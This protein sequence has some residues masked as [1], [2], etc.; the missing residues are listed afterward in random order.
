MAHRSRW[1]LRAG[2]L[3]PVIAVAIMGIAGVAAIEDIADRRNT[4]S[5]IEQ[6]AVTIQDRILAEI[7]Q[8]QRAEEIFT[9]LVADRLGI[10]VMVEESDAARLR[11]TLTPLAEELNLGYLGVYTRDNRELLRLGAGDGRDDRTALTSAL[12]GQASSTLAGSPQGLDIS[13]AGPIRSAGGVIGAVLVSTTVPS[14]GLQGLRGREAAEL[15]VYQ[16]G[17]LVASTTQDTRIT[18]LLQ[19]NRGSRDALDQLNDGLDD[20]NF[21]AAGFPLARNGMLVTIVAVDDLITAAWNR[22]VVGVIGTAALMVA[23]LLVYFMVAE[24]MTRTLHSVIGATKELVIG[25]Y[26]WRVK[27]STIRELD[28]LAG[29][30]NNLGQQLE[31]HVNELSHRAF[32]DPLT[33]LPNRAMLLDRLET[34]LARTRRSGRQIALIFCDLDNF[35]VVNDTLGHEAGDELLIS[36]ANRLQSTIRPGDTSARL[37]GDEFVVLL[38]DLDRP[39]DAHSVASRV[40]EQ[41]RAPFLLGGQEVFISVSIGAKVSV[42][43]TDQPDDL[44]RDAD[45]A[46]YRAKANGKGRYEIFD[47]VTDRVDPDRLQ[48]ETDLR[49]AIERDELRV[50]YQPIWHLATRRMVGVEALVRWQHPERGLLAPG[51]FVPLAEQIGLIL[52]I[53]RFVLTQACR[54]A[55][56]WHLRYPGPAP[57]R[58]SVNLSTRVFERPELID[59]IGATLR[60][61]GLDPSL[62]N[63]EITETVMMRQVERTHTELHKLKEL[64]VKLSVDD[65][66][67]G[68]SSLAYLRRFPINTVKVDRAFVEHLGQDPEDTAIVGAIVTLARTLQLEVVAEGIETADQLAHL[69]NLGCDYGQGFY[70]ARPVPANVIEALLAEGV[71]TTSGHIPGN[72][73]S[74]PDATL[75]LPAVPAG[76]KA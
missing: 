7:Q 75:A 10:A 40:I 50:Y 32:H 35:K 74:D 13:A 52:P 5:L 21:R 57:L 39:D 20:L 24:D 47:A 23:L 51:R 14:E 55:M 8:R 53:G 42:S 71:V 18:Q 58:M 15:A 44:L 41:M 38:E 34:A 22:A 69:L 2:L 33:G 17:R 66:G 62:L 16:D 48:L 45:A 9:Q 25:K 30:I 4:A 27:P 3:G 67:T 28:D 60:E 65:F 29:A 54:D 31:V 46:M 19:R 43:S 6:R 26:S 59:D 61:T 68:Y 73:A 56:S 1:G 37:G 63:L 72:G 70:F 76:D 64:G 36:V 12:A 11:Q 49:W